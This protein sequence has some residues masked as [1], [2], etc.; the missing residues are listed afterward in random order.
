VA[1]PF[2]TFED[3]LTV[4]V[5]DLEVQLVHT[6]PAHTTNDV[7]AWIPECRLL[8]SGDLVFNGGCPF[9]MMGSVSGSLAALD[10]L[11]SLGA[12]RIVPGHGDVC[13]PEVLDDLEG[14]VRFVVDTA[15]AG[16][17]AGW[18]PLETAQRADLGRFASWG[19]TERLAPN[20]HR[21]YSELRG[22]PLGA[23]LDLLTM[24]GDMATYNGGALPHCLA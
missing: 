13:G 1:P 4:W 21:A 15:R 20:L 3:R 6:G 11:R 24:I 23:P 8:L 2:V 5:D 9:M 17:D 14:Y 22:E 7:Y 19:E 12:E 10:E 18:S 16:F